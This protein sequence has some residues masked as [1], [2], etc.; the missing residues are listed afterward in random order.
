LIL[1]S[2]DVMSQFLSEPMTLNSEGPFLGVVST[3]MSG[4]S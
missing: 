4:G 1:W 3:R 2:S